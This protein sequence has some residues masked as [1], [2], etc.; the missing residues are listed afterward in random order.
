[1]EHY[2]WTA[3]VKPGMLDEYRRRHAEIW[4]EMVETLREAGICNY[5]IFVCGDQLFGY[6]ECRDGPDGA[7]AV[8][9][10]SPVVAR[11]DEY[12]KD[13]MDM[14][15]DPVTGAQPRLEEAWRL[16]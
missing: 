2:A 12:M 1:M 6:Y 10:A 8:Q 4:P 11:W 13:V 3:R 15:P 14:T 9:A 7:A 16:D 5:T